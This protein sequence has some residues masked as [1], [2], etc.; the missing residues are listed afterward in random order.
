MSG[1]S[2]V[3][4]DQNCWCFTSDNSCLVYLIRPK[5]RGA[6]PPSNRSSSQTPSTS[7][8]SG[9]SHCCPGKGRAQGQ[10]TLDAQNGM[11]DQERKAQ[12]QVPEASQGQSLALDKATHSELLEWRQGMLWFSET[13]GPDAM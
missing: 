6:L 13:S 10:E 3:L 5:C 4:T 2:S 9:C 11:E 1:S 12:G 7:R 8:V